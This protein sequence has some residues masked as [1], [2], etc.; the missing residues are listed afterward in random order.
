MNKEKKKVPFCVSIVDYKALE[1]YLENM[2]LKG[3]LIEKYNTFTIEF[4]KIKPA[5]YKFNVSLFYKSPFEYSNEEK[6]NTYQERYEELGWTFVKNKKVFQICYALEEVDLIPIEIDPVEEYKIMKSTFYKTEFISLISL[7]PVSLIGLSNI[8]RFDYTDLYR[9]M[10]LWGMLTPLFM[11][12]IIFPFI[13]NMFY[14]RKV[15]RQVIKGKG[16]PVSS[17]RAVKIKNK[18]MLFIGLIYLIFTI[19]IIGQSISYQKNYIYLAGFLPAISGVIFAVWYKKFVKKRKRAIRKNIVMFIALLAITIALSISLVFGVMI[20]LVSNHDKNRVKDAVNF[21]DYKV[22]TLS[23]LGV[24]NEIIKNNL[25]KEGS[26]FVPEYYTYY[27]IADKKSIDTEY[28]K[29]RNEKICN[30]IYDAMLKKMLSKSYNHVIKGDHKKWEVDEVYYLNDDYNYVM[31]KKDN[32]I[33]MLD[34]D[35]DFSDSE[36]IERCKKVLKK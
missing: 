9:N 30:Y 21:K 7:L 12:M 6:I 13:Y 32:V 15:K 25:R 8:V 2:A 23:D 33:V 28:I 31:M 36:I 14:L 3:W 1:K 16:L 17:W 27:E 18:S 11:L 29:A 5:K 22:I 20:K 35:F 26:I 4:R 24:E 34:G 19:L 10:A